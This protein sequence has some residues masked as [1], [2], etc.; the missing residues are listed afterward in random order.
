M[1][2]VNYDEK[3]A[4]DRED[5]SDYSAQSD[6]SAESGDEFGDDS[7]VDKPAL[8]VRTLAMSCHTFLH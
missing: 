4:K 8:K 1:P 2:Q 3:H 7:N 6:E 5:A